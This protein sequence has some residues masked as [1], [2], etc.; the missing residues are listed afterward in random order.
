M[1]TDAQIIADYELTKVK[2]Q[3]ARNLGVHLSKVKRCLK[4]HNIESLQPATQP[5]QQRS[6]HREKQLEAH[7][8]QLQEQL[9]LARKPRVTY[10]PSRAPKK[11]GNYKRVIIPDTHGCKADK[12]ALGAF[13]ADLEKI[14]DVRE[15]V[16]LGDHLDCDGFLTTHVAQYIPREHYTFEED[17]SATNELLDSLQR[18][19]PKA[20]IHYLEGNH[21]WRVERWI[22]KQQQ[23]D[24]KDAEFLYRRLG[25]ASVLSLEKRG[26]HFY[27]QGD[28]HMG[29][30]VRG[31]IKLGRCYFMHGTAT[32]SKV[33]SHKNL[34][35]YAECLVHGHNHQQQSASGHF[36]EGSAKG[37]WCPG[38]LC[39]LNP[40]WS[41]TDT[42]SWTHGYGLQCVNPDGTFHHLNIPI[43]EGRSLLSQL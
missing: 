5:E 25:P 12:K 29:I 39:E 38:C 27:R 8:A 35:K 37:V 1:P 9:D 10:K 18:L 40:I 3:T 19:M 4:R 22:M 7:I 34:Y 17:I 14:E 2:A 36:M 41:H 21:E 26:I 11:R 33:A 43:I 15:V 13:L 31:A 23:L 28:A 42:C 16:M 24:S 20:T 6:T 32:S 30:P